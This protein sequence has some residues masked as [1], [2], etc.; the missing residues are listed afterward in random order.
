MHL[1]N[2]KAES[3]HAVEGRFACS[4]EIVRGA[5]TRGS[6]YSPA[7]RRS[8]NCPRRFATVVFVVR[9]RCAT[10]VSE[11]AIHTNTIRARNA[12]W[13]DSRGRASSIARAPRAQRR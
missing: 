7:S 3:P 8:T 6:S 4:S 11:A 12:P 10:T 2:A 1:L 9:R 5:P 13:P